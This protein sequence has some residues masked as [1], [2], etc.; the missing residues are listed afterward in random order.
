VMLFE[1][2]R[3]LPSG[4]SKGFERHLIQNYIRIVDLKLIQ[5]NII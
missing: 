1:A 3:D 4:S 2:F 5:T